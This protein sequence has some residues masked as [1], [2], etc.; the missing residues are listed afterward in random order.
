MAEVT[1]VDGEIRGFPPPLLQWTDL[2]AVL[3]FRRALIEENYL[4]KY[5][6]KEIYFY[7]LF[8]CVLA[9]IVTYGS[10]VVFGITVGCVRDIRPFGNWSDR[11]PSNNN[12]VDNQEV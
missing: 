3:V 11:Y 12:F 7:L 10:D 4:L 8:S 5:S 9:E 2:I 1:V 6:K